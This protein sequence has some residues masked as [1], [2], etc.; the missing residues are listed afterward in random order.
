M[1]GQ[2]IRYSTAFK[3]KLLLKLNPVNGVVLKKVYS[4]LDQLFQN[5]FLND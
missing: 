5:V 2:T 1:P 3:L 4:F